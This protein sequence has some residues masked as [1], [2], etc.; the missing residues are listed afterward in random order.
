MPA[1]SAMNRRIVEVT[2][3]A[4]PSDS[5]VVPF[6]DEIKKKDGQKPAPNRIIFMNLWISPMGTKKSEGA[7]EP[8]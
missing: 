2:T 5:P 3:V 8:R 4:I 6:L 7:D 1:D